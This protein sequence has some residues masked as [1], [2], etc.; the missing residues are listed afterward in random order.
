MISTLPRKAELLQHDL[1][2]IDQ[3]HKKV[4]TNTLQVAD[5]FSKRPSEVNR[6]IASLTKKGLCRIAPS[7]YLNQ[8]GKQQNYYELNRDQFLLVVMGFTGDKADQFKTDFIRLFNQQ[9]AELQ[10]W[11]NGRLIATNATKQANDQV[12]VLQADLAKVIPA[13]NRCKMLFNHIQIAINKS[14]TGVGKKIDRDS[15]PIDQLNEI[16]RL[17]HAVQAE[18]KQLKA[19]GIAPEQ[20]RDDVLVLIKAGKEKTRSGHANGLSTNF[21]DKTNI[22]YQANKAIQ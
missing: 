21:I 15:L 18:I 20:I 5:Y 7:Y 16:E 13:S 8:Q 14:V 4:I 10:Q 3:H 6:R 2:D 12:A 22:S 9:E 19:D 1:V 11:Q 17:E